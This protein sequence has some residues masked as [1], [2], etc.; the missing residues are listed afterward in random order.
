MAKINPGFPLPKEGSIDRNKTFVRISLEVEIGFELAR[1]RV[2]DDFFGLQLH[3]PLKEGCSIERGVYI[4]IPGDCLRS[5]QIVEKIL[6]IIRLAV[7][8]HMIAHG[9]DRVVELNEAMRHGDSHV[10]TDNRS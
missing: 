1:L 7:F 6:Q 10:L 3:Q 5:L 9:L 2:I 8:T 4:D